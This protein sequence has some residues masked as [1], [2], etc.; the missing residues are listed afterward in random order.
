VLEEDFH[1]SFPYLFEYQGE[2]LMCPETA[3]AND[4]RIYQCDEFPLKW[5]LK[6][7][8][9]PDFYAADTMLFEHEDRWWMLTST[10][11]AQIDEFCSELNI[12]YSD[13]PLSSD[14]TPHAQNPVIIDSS[15]ARNG[16]ILRK[17][18]EIY[19]VGQEQGFATYGQAAGIY[20]IV[21]LTPDEF[22]EVKIARVS[23]EFE[24]GAHGGH[25]LHSDGKVTVFDYRA[26][27]KV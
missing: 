6:K 2:L 4:I 20:K 24:D 16:G 10:D 26:W 3:T 12:F 18:G 9:K 7:I 27:V 5:T 22:V 11:E 8:I 25:H 23:P 13:S 15:R 17:D 19:R 21:T 1:L 14:W